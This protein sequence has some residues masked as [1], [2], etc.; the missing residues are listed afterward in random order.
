VTEDHPA[1]RQIIE[2]MLAPM[3][4]DVTL[5]ANGAQAVDAFK[6]HDWELVLLDR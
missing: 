3:G 5:V 6:R 2:L 1:N 4:V